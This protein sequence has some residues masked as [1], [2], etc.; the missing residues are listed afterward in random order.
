MDLMQRILS[1]ALLALFSAYQ[2]HSPQAIIEPGLWVDE[3]AV[4]VSFQRGRLDQR[5]RLEVDLPVQHSYANLRHALVEAELVAPDGSAWKQ[6]SRQIRLR[7]QAGSTTVRL[8]APMNA[9]DWR[10]EVWDEHR[11][12]YRIRGEALD[13][14]PEGGAKPLAEGVAALSQA[15]RDNFVLSLAMPS[16]AAERLG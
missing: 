8:Q 5:G 14:A 9:S 10:A 1:A 13:P 16:G 3:A 7:P 15:Y 12:R 4:R 6:L 11:L 2:A